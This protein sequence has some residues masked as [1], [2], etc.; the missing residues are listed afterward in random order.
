M[1]EVNHKNTRTTSMTLF[2]CFYYLN[3]FTTFSSVSTIDFEQVK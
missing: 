2:W 1:L 3:I